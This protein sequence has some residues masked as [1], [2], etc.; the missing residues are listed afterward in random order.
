MNN[1]GPNCEEEAE[2]SCCCTVIRNLRVRTTELQC[3]TSCNPGNWLL[4][5]EKMAAVRTSHQRRHAN[6]GT[7]ENDLSNY[8]I[9]VQ[10]VF[11]T[12]QLFHSRSTQIASTARVSSVITCICGER[13]RQA[14]KR[15]RW[16]NYARAHIDLWLACRLMSGLVSRPRVTPQDDA[17]DYTTAEMEWFNKQNNL[18]WWWDS[19]ET[20]WEPLEASTVDLLAT[21]ELAT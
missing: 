17:E 13:D 4:A 5:N 12:M 15:Y 2:F 9:Y 6:H 19:M 8:S 1:S 18:K 10:S 20:T 21:V 3:H 7:P 14:L 16:P 11:V